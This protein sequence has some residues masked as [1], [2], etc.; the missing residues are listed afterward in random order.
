MVREDL[1]LL[2]RYL[3]RNGYGATYTIAQANKKWV[4]QCVLIAVVDLD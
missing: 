4:K 3:L 2:L 1:F